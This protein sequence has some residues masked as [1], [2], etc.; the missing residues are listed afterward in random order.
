MMDFVEFVHEF[1]FMSNS[2][3]P[4]ESCIL[5]KRDE[6]ELPGQLKTTISLLIYAE[7][8]SSNLTLTPLTLTENTI[9]A[10]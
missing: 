6:N 10:G 3:S 4:I 5:N 8:K 1:V 9:I 2:M 7:G